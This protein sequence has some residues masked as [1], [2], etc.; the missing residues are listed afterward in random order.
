M[1]S[2]ESHPCESCSELFSNKAK[3][4]HHR[5][6][7]H[8]LPPLFK[9]DGKVYKVV[10]NKGRLE[11]PFDA[12]PKAYLN[13]D[14]YQTHLRKVHGGEFEAA[15]DNTPSPDGTFDLPLAFNFSVVLI[16]CIDSPWAWNPFLR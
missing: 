10:C 6:N 9:K 5:Y 13:R 15:E 7:R 8:T 11:C 14:D 12:C 4:R 16:S 3:L 1:P 2:S